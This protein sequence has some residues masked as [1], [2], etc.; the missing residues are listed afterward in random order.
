MHLSYLETISDEFVSFV[1]PLSPGHSIGVSG[2]YFSPGSS[3]GADINGTL[4]IIR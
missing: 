2:Q 4:A 3:K 1:H